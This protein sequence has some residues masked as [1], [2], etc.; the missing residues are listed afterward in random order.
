MFYRNK[1]NR[2]L[3][4]TVLY[5]VN[6]LSTLRDIAVG[7]THLCAWEWRKLGPRLI[8][9]KSSGPEVGLISGDYCNTFAARPDFAIIK[10]RAS[11]SCYTNEIPF[12]L[13]IAL[14]NSS[15]T[16]YVAL[17]TGAWCFGPKQA[18][19]ADLVGAAPQKYLA[20]TNSSNRW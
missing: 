5:S 1:E 2:S 19:Y 18:K 20:G 8:S 10:Y 16:F 12:Y 17:S 13:H 11:T 6:R 14:D 15:L 4:G 9:P 7:H 3:P